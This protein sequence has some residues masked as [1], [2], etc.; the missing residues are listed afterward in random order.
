[1]TTSPPGVSG[2]DFVT[3]FVKD[4]SA[5]TAFYGDVL[6]LPRSAEYGSFHGSE[7]ETGSLT[8]QVMEAAAIGREF[9][10]STHPIALHVDDVAA[11]R[12]GLEAGGVRFFGDTIDSGVCHMAIFED[13]DGNTL[14]FHNRY[15]PR[16]G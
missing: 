6:G 2:V 13:P 9:Q 14:M 8:L 12:A 1:M 16:P 4:Y 15:A 10:P 11:A 7:Y 5:A 3:V